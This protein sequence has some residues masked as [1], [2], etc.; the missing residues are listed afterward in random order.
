MPLP[1]ITFFIDSN[2]QETTNYL[3]TLNSVDVG[4][5]CDEMRFSNNGISWSPWALF[6]TSYSWDF[7]LYGGAYTHGQRFVFAE[8]RNGDG[9]TKIY[10]YIELVSPSTRAKF[11]T[12]PTQRNDNSKLVDIPY[13]G[14]ERHIMGHAVDLIEIEFDLYG[15]FIG[16]EKKLSVKDNDPANTGVTGLLFTNAGEDQNIVWDL[17]EDA[18]ADEFWNTCKVRFKCHYGK[19]TSDWFT[20]NDFSISTRDVDP[21]EKLGKKGAPG[22]TIKIEIE[23]FDSNGTPKDADF[24]P[25]ITSIKD[26]NGI[27]KV[28]VNLQMIHDG[29]GYYFYNYA[30]LTT[31]PEGQWMSVITYIMNGETFTKS[32]PFYIENDF[33]VVTPSLENVCRVYGTLYCENGSP[34]ENIDV[35]ILH[36]DMSDPGHFN[37]TVIGMMPIISTTDANGFF[38]VDVIQNSEVIVYIKDLNYR[39]RAQIP[40]KVS[41]KFTE[42][43]LVLPTP[44]RD[45]FGNRIS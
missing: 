19:Y 14:I 41:V 34:A 24:I 38:S 2:A 25:N 45:E 44:P 36:D 7:R 16:Q 10:D 17:L 27:E 32:V 3:V 12:A 22:D 33:I 20:T 6:V 30:T 37:P 4:G 18:D 28:T 35:M 11:I 43:S 26:P 21:D 40:E 31:D 9:I 8:Y 1:N 5:D 39:R 13:I 42:M 29:D 23:L 15:Q